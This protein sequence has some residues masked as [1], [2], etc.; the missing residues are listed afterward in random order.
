MA[1]RHRFTGGLPHGPSPS[2]EGGTSL[3]VE[4]RHNGESRRHGEPGWITGARRDAG[5]AYRCGAA[6]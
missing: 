5:S 2:P 1:G 4:L 6:G 3:P